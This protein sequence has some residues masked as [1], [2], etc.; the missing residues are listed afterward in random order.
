MWKGEEI[1]ISKYSLLYNSYSQNN[2]IETN[3]D[4]DETE[5]G[6]ETKAKEPTV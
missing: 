3:Q 1:A 6:T 2:D 5:S 4:L